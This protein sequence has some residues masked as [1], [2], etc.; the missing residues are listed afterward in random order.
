MNSFPPELVYVLLFGAVLLFQYL[1]KRFGPQE[2]QDS[3]RQQDLPEIPG[4]VMESP[5][6]SPVFTRTIRS[7]LLIRAKRSRRSV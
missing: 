2:Q 1:M 6:A 7:L 3:A 4:E 5:A